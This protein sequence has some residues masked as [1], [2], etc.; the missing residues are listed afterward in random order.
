MRQFEV[1]SAYR[2]RGLSLP[3]RAT[4]G[5]AGYDLASAEDVVVPPRSVAL[6]PTGLKVTMP[7]G[8]FLAIYIRSSLAVRR[9]LM[10]V[11]GTGV[12]DRDYYN[13]PDTEGHILIA[14]Y[15]R[16]DAAV[17]IARGERVAQG[18]FHE[19]RCTDDDMPASVDRQ[20]GFG[21]TGRS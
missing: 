1:V 8:E 10:P 9:G 21:S 2:D 19:Y 16:T 7:D 13:S 6:I 15:N 14:V 11:N 20:G 12:I 4:A 17:T 18:V 5:S 3:R